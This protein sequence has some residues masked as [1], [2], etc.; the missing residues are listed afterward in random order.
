[1]HGGGYVWDWAFYRCTRVQ[2]AAI[3]ELENRPR[4]ALLMYL[5]VCY[6]D[7]NG[8]NN[9]AGG[10]HDTRRNPPFSLERSF[11]AAGVVSR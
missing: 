8:P 2:M 7:I 9:M 5:E 1:M 4:D 3:L 10:G 6:L 11:L